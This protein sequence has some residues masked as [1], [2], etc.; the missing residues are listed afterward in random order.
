MPKQRILGG[1]DTESGFEIIRAERIDVCVLANE[2]LGTNSYYFR[3][4]TR[5]MG[6]LLRL[7]ARRELELECGFRL[8]VW[9][10][11]SIPKT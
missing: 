2:N 4:R 5:A 11:K 3:R 1:D 7:E 8:T 6:D 9:G 10:N